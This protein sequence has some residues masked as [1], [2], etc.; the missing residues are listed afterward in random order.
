MD[1]PYARIA[2]LRRQIAEHD[3]RYHTFDAP[4]ITDAE[5]DALVRELR[6]LEAAHPETITAESPTQRVGDRI[7]VEFAPVTHSVPMLSLDNAFSEAEVRAFDRRCREALGG[8]PIM[9]AAEPKMDGLAIALTYRC[10]ELVQAAT[11]GDGQTGEDVTHT[12][13]TIPSVPARLRGEVPELLEVRGEVYMPWAGFHAYNQRA[14][15]RGEKPLINP[16][17]AAAGS[18]RQLDPELAARR[19]LEFCAYGVGRIVADGADSELAPTHSAQLRRVEAFG[20]P[21]SPYLEVRSGVEELLRYYEDLLQRRATLPFAIDGVVYKIDSL[22]QQRRLGFALRAPR[23]AIAHKFPA[24]EATTQLLA[25]DIQVGR[26]G[27]LTPVAK[28]EPVF[29]GGATV[30]NATLHNEDEVRR[31]DVRVGD[32]VV[33]RRAGD[34]I[35]EVVRAVVE[36]RPPTVAEQ[37]PFDLYARLGGR[38]PECGSPIGRSEGQ[39]DWRCTGGLVCPAQRKEALRHYASRRA[40]DIEGLGE[41]LIEQLVDRG[42][43]QSV[44][45]LYRLN[46]ADLL[47]LERMGEKSAANLL[48]EIER[49]KSTSLER[50]L[51]ALGIRDV[52][53]ATA[54]ALARHFGSLEALIDA[55]DEAWTRLAQ[56]GE[57]SPDDG[58]ALLGSRLLE[59]PDVGPV[60]ARRIAEFFHDPRNVEILHHLRARGVRWPESAPRQGRDGPLAGQTVVLTGTLSGMTREAAAARLEAL[61]AK[62]AGSVSK[63]TSVVIAGAEAGSKLTKARELGIPIW[64][65]ERLNAFFAAHAPSP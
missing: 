62:V 3:R 10:G 63:K 23:F 60:V 56:H 36:Q 22:E 33:V 30:S 54:K 43:V 9:Y 61:G 49:S 8:E 25:I 20:L 50:L 44:A 2:E 39:A 12:V 42:R 45:D 14:A 17:N 52:G 5:Y 18:V 35:P 34:V 57:G 28:L 19:P 48:A 7:R 53:E 38:C 46:A 26:T 15:E 21:I 37:A 6:A 31:K 32:R 40:M 59:V 27:R 55:A 11:R 58:K 29:V 47:D 51:Y 24:E 13:R 1:D 65:E 64:D 4:L 41:K 16:R